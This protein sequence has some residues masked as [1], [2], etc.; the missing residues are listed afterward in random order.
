M[1]RNIMYFLDEIQKVEKFED[2]V[3][4]LRAST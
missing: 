1:I 3:N 2:V 4:S